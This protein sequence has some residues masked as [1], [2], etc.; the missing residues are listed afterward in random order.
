M[1]FNSI[2]QEIYGMLMYFTLQLFTNMTGVFVK[3]LFSSQI[4]RF[5]IV[6]FLFRFIF[7]IK[8]VMEH[9]DLSLVYQM[10]DTKKKLGSC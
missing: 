3:L 6:F 4:F 5:R 10:A 2:W 1:L 7:F 9:Y 8:K